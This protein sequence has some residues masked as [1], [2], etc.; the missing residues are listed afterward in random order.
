[1]GTLKNQECAELIQHFRTCLKTNEVLG[2]L[3]ETQ[4]EFFV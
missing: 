1:M 3:K 2:R 4:P